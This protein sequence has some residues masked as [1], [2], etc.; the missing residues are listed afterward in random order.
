MAIE[1]PHLK[2][3]SNRSVLVGSDSSEQIFKEGTPDASALARLAVIEDALGLGYLDQL[4]EGLKQQ[5]I[6]PGSA[7]PEHLGIIETLVGSVTSE[8]GRALVG[9]SVLQLT[10]KSI[11]PEQDV[12]LHKSGRGQFSWA[13][14]LPMRSLD[15]K[16]IT[17]SLR[18]FD[19]LRLNS[20]GFMMTRSLAENY[21]Y[22]KL[23]KAAI[24]GAKDA[25]ITLVDVVQEDGVDPRTLLEALISILI[26]RS[27]HFRE[28]G[29]EVLAKVNGL[30]QSNPKSGWAESLIQTHISNSS[31]SARLLEVA[32]HSLFQV[33]D[34]YRNLPGKLEPL[35][36]MRSANKKHGN[37]ADI[38]VVGDEDNTYIIEAWDAK[39]GKPYLRDELEELSDKLEMHPEVV[40]SG[41]VVDRTPELDDELNNRIAELENFHDVEILILTF[42]EWIDR[43]IIRANVSKEDLCKE[44]LLAYSECLALRRLDQAPIDEPAD[45]WLQDLN[46]LL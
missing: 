25:W 24:R 8:V 21:P 18:K 33:L 3:Y 5:Q 30:L 32:M 9:L 11:T 2:V 42:N 13:E 34:S 27:E 17:P 45:V 15:S 10:I 20:F 29:D 31:Y 44:W 26:N 6:I 22:T 4:I 46:R 37:V 7:D 28:L 16:Y 19:L 40:T 38:E 35:S 1:E 41:F 43:Q 39:Y 36:Q 23:Y 12:R 14:G